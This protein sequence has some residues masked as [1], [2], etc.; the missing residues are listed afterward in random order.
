MVAVKTR[1]GEQAKVCPTCGQ[2]VGQGVREAYGL[3]TLPGLKRARHDADLTQ[4]E[5]ASLVGTS[6]SQ[7]SRLENLSQ[8]ATRSLRRAL[9]EA[10]EV[11]GDELERL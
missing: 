3:A 4:K 1:R 8:M 7:I 5:L 9:A 2:V 6:N 11:T 10:L